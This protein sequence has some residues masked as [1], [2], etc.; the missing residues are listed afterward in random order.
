M[1]Y[2]HILDPP[3]ECGL[4]LLVYF[5]RDRGVA[6]CG[7]GVATFLIRYAKPYPRAPIWELGGGACGLGVATFLFRP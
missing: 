3:G 1:S 5:L 6:W 7:L 4:G 2:F